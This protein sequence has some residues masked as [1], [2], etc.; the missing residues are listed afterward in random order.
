MHLVVFTVSEPEGCFE[1]GT[2]DTALVPLT[3]EEYIRSGYRI[4][5]QDRFERTIAVEA[6]E[7]SC[8]RKG[9]NYFSPRVCV[10]LKHENLICLF[11]VKTM[12]IHKDEGTTKD[13]DE[14]KLLYVQDSKHIYTVIIITTKQ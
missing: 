1:N 7:Q 5:N 4:R 13:N 8:L 11:I 10:T 3:Q 14:K 2:A 6:C 9:K 12:H